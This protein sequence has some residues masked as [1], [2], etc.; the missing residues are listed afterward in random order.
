MNSRSEG[1]QNESTL[2]SRWEQSL[3]PIM[4]PIL[5]TIAPLHRWNLDSVS[6][7]FRY[8]IILENI[9]PL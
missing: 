3:V 5:N 9:G 7:K 4:V 6:L 2:A 8:R 1:D